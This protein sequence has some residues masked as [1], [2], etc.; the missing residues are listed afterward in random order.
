MKPI[1]LMLAS[2]SLVFILLS[3]KKDNNNATVPTIFIDEIIITD[4]SAN[5][6]TFV[7]RKIN[8][9][10]DNRK[11]VTAIFQYGIGNTPPLMR[12]LE[13]DVYFYNGND[14]IP[15][16]TISVYN[17][18]NLLY[19]STTTY[20][21]YDNNKRRISDSLLTYSSN[22]FFENMYKYSYGANNIFIQRTSGRFQTDIKFDTVQI[23]NR[24]NAVYRRDIGPFVVPY[25]VQ[26]SF[27]NN[28]S[29]FAGL[30]N[31]RAL[32]LYLDKDDF[33]YF[34]LSRNTNNIRNISTTPLQGTGTQQ[35]TFVYEYLPN[36][37]PEKLIVDLG[38]GNFKMYDFKYKTL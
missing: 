35:V 4:S 21:V 38:M 36:G 22:I 15:Y 13:S 6:P 34:F 25:Q 9:E 5:W 7:S 3:C 28:I 32:K 2:A 23:D 14:S 11:R 30:S 20:H 37:Y 24:G 8:Y 27:D 26:Q 33:Y 18:P 29:P 17:I 19:D 10:Y 16:K 31:F 1:Y 12:P